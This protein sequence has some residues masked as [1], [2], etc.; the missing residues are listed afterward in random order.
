[1]MDFFL[2]KKALVLWLL[3]FGDKARIKGV[4]DPWQTEPAKSA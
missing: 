1:M 2:K 4:Q 3:Q